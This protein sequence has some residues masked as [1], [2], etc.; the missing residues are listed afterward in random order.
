MPRR[1][2]AEQR[3]FAYLRAFRFYFVKGFQQLFHGGALSKDASSSGWVVQFR[4]VTTTV[5][6]SMANSF[7]AAPC[8]K[9]GMTRNSFSVVC[10]GLES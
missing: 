6:E 10:C 4:V 2:T 8:H 5:G 7:S 9:I 3:G 1:L